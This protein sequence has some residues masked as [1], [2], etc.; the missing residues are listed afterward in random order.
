[1][2]PALIGRK[3]LVLDEGSRLPLTFSIRMENSQA[4]I[5]LRLNQDTTVDVGE[6]LSIERAS[7]GIDVP[8]DTQV[9]LAYVIVLKS[10]KRIPI[11]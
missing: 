9:T 3:I 7:P 5:E 11:E 6:I 8:T 2:P 10:G 4:E 1:M